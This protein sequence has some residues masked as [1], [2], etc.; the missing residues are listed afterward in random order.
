LDIAAFYLEAHLAC[1]MLFISALPYWQGIANSFV[2]HS[3]ASSFEVVLR[4]AVEH[5]FCI[6]WY[7]VY[8]WDEERETEDMRRV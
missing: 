4:L 1:I 5:Y 2:Y 3:P 8:T 7:R 6:G